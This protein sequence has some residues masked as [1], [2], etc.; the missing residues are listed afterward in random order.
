MS[1][2]NK[3]KSSSKYFTISAYAL[4]TL[5]IIGIAFIAF[6]MGL[7]FINDIFINR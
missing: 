7:G 2:H 6:L 1:K 3:F 5:L 4:G